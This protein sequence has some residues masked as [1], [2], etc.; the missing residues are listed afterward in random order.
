[1]QAFP[2]LTVGSALVLQTALHSPD[3]QLSVLEKQAL[4]PPAHSSVQVPLSQFCVAPKQ[5]LSSSH[6]TS[7]AYVAGQSITAW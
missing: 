4:T 3:P 2:Q 1:M 7:H 5:A 6:T